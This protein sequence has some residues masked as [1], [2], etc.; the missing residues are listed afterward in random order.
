[1]KRLGVWILILA[2]C[3]TGCRPAAVEEEPAMPTDVPSVVTDDVPMYHD[4]ISGFYGTLQY[5]TRYESAYLAERE[6]EAWEREARHIFAYLNENAHPTVETFIDFEEMEEDF[7]TYAKAQAL[8]DAYI[9]YTSLLQQDTESWGEAV[10]YGT[11]FGAGEMG[12][13]KEIYRNFV[14]N[15]YETMTWLSDISP[16]DCY[17]FLPEEELERLNQDGRI[18]YTMGNYDLAEKEGAWK[19]DILENPIDGWASQWLYQDGATYMMSADGWMEA[20]LWETELRHAYEVFSAHANP[21]VE[22]EKT[23]VG[24]REALLGFAPVNGECLALFSY[25]NAFM[26]KDQKDGFGAGTL[27]RVDHGI[28]CARYY[29]RAT[30]LLWKALLDR[31]EMDAPEWQFDSENS[32]E[33]LLE[34]RFQGTEGRE[35]RLWGGEL[36]TSGIFLSESGYKRLKT[37]PQAVDTYSRSYNEDVCVEVFRDERE[38]RDVV[39]LT[40]ENGLCQEIE[41]TSPRHEAGIGGVT[42]TDVNFDGTDDLLLYIG[43]SR[44]GCRFNAAFLGKPGEEGYRY[45]PSFSE[46]PSPRVDAE[47]GVIWGGSDYNYGHYYYAYE[48]LNGEYQMTHAL[49]ALSEGGSHPA[50]RESLR[51]DGAMV[52]VRYWEAPAREKGWS[53][54][55][56]IMEAYVRTGTVWEGWGWCDIRAYERYG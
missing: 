36:L 8:L 22:P 38:Q 10:M 13:R 12:A 3:L 18:E 47:H 9:G 32:R 53:N 50:C 33:E 25:S 45:A 6:T 20:K 16:L 42:R 40:S 48:I 27:A 19:E 28:N 41:L 56:D 5:D 35:L 49:E 11:G 14:E 44:G 23:V 55:V 39:L 7:F 15:W 31:L 37:P 43:G 17:I 21:A 4:P 1:M 24:A 30:L 2:L 26:G 46:I 54:P 34:R 52:E 29:R 51:K